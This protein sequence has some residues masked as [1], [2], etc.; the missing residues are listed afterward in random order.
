[1]VARVAVA[2]I[3]TLLSILATGGVAAAQGELVVTVAIENARPLG[4]IQDATPAGEPVR[5]PGPVIPNPL[6]PAS[7]PVEPVLA[8][9]PANARVD[10][11]GSHVTVPTTIG[12]RTLTLEWAP[13]MDDRDVRLGPLLDWDFNSDRS[14][15]MIEREA[16]WYN[17]RFGNPIRGTAEL[18]DALRQVAPELV[19]RFAPVSFLF[20]RQPDLA[21][22]ED[23]VPHANAADGSGVA[24]ADETAN[25]AVTDPAAA[26]RSAG[27]DAARGPPE[28]ARH[29]EGLAL[30]AVPP[31]SLP[32]IPGLVLAAFVFASLAVAAYHM[33]RRRSLLENNVRGRIL[34]AVHERPGTTVTELARSAGVTHQTALYH[35]ELLVNGGMLV[36]TRKGKRRHFFANDGNFSPEERAV[37]T[38]ASDPGS[39]QILNLV[40]GTPDLSK[41]AVASR[42]AIS[43]NTVNWHLRKLA[44]SG[45]VVAEPRGGAV[46]LRP[47]PEGLATLERVSRKMTEA[48]G[49][50]AP[51]ATA[52]T[53]RPG[54]HISPP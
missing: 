39:M 5:L 8:P 6:G 40:R 34:Q 50:A 23:A 48:A 24:A 42:L 9:L 25:A 33:L 26:I 28:G 10:E 20:E 43:K 41:S 4:D 21:R 2:S 29:V 53:L 31:A 1:M 22:T 49:L 15:D 45:L 51:A 30:S 46:V 37:A 36:E 16:D 11:R 12:P 19:L 52:E 47:R 54:T 35:V 14:L 3:V 32:P 38:V 18:F 17:A 44:A 13:F 27:L 7:D